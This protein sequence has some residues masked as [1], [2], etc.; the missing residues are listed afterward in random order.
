MPA[1]WFRPPQELRSRGGGPSPARLNGRDRSRQ[2]SGTPGRRQGN[3]ADG[4][5]GWRPQR[6]PAIDAAAVFDDLAA[7][8]GGH[9]QAESV[10]ILERRGHLLQGGGLKELSA[11]EA[12]FPSQK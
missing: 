12:L 9:G 3:G 7:V 1:R 2:G 5:P 10:V 4:L 6:L 11:K 8:L